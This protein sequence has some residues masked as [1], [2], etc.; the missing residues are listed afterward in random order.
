MGQSES[1]G[2]KLFLSLFKH[3][4][5]GRSL[6]VSDKFYNFVQKIS[7]WFPEEGSLTLK[8]WK[9]V[10]KMLPPSE[11][12]NIL[13]KKHLAWEYVNTLCQ[14]LTDQSIRKVPYKIILKHV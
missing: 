4:L 1:K 10:G 6:K 3:M 13:K 2:K 8:D 7:S 5:S 12:T 9:Q 14:D 11:G